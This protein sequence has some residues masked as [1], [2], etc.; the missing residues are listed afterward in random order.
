MC[1]YGAVDTELT[2]KKENNGLSVRKHS[3]VI[4]CIILY[5][6]R[7]KRTKRLKNLS[8]YV[9]QKVLDPPHRFSIT[10]GVS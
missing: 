10:T 4:Y 1:R 6:S 8:N 5:K 3:P 2:K 9:N 7:N